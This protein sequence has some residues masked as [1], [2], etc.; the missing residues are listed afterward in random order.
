MSRL[1]SLP[2]EIVE[3]GDL[4]LIVQVNRSGQWLWTLTL[5]NGPNRTDKVDTFAA[6]SIPFNDCSSVGRWL[7]NNNASS[8]FRQAEGVILDLNK[9]LG[10]FH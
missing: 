2:E 4:R 10:H 7:S 3:K 1:D 9:K 6:N 8:L 5:F